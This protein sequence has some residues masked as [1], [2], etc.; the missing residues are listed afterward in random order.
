MGRQYACNP[1][2]IFEFMYNNYADKYIYVWCL[3]DK[4][5]LPE[6]YNNIKVCGYFTL[7][8]IFLMMTAKYIITNQAVEPYFPFRKNQNIIYTWH[9]GGAYKRVDDIKAYQRCKWSRSI[10]KDIRSRMITYVI[11]SCKKFT[12]LHSDI[13]N[14]TYNKFLPIGMPRNDIL[15][16][17]DTMIKDKVYKYYNI[18]NAQ[19][20]VLYAP[21]FRGDF[22]SPQKAEYFSILNI[23]KI[24]MSLKAKYKNNFLFFYR[25]HYNIS[26]RWI[27]MSNI[28][29]A[30]DYHDM[31]ELLCATDILITD[32]SSS[33][34][35]FS[36]T[37]KPCFVYAPD[38]KKY[39]AEQGFY[40]PVE[41]WPFPLAETNEKLIE[42]ILN[43]D[44]EEYKQAIKRHH[45]NLG[46]YETGTATNQFCEKVFS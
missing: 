39:Q 23:E 8:Y 10:M 6:N 1:K 22:R 37:F 30:S 32:Y 13:W 11:S 9:G 5:K 43:F 12:E 28:I 24:L 2:Y 14:I 19:K 25:T 46:S 18:N 44:E 40:T 31:Q 41:E 27:N 4:K 29:S 20:I 7:E 26:D 45:A 35:D 34:W 42:N 33:I 15:F 17:H 38:L 21:T 36:L 3:R 16:S